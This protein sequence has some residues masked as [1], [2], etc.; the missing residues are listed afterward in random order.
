[1]KRLN[2]LEMVPQH[3][4][5]ADSQIQANHA[6]QNE[7]PNNLSLATSTHFNRSV[8]WSSL[9]AT[10]V[11]Q[12]INIGHILSAENAGEMVSICI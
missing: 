5:T 6:E 7:T 12:G 11:Q 2:L 9:L 8:R 4:V 10:Q 1:M 3:A